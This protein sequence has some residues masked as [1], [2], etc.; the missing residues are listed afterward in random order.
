MPKPPKVSVGWLDGRSL[1]ASEASWCTHTGAAANKF[2]DLEAPL[3]AYQGRE[4]RVEAINYAVFFDEELPSPV[5]A[6]STVRQI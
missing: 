3:V 4:M 1:Q 6:G 5:W 2:G